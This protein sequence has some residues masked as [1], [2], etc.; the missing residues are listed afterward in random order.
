MGKGFVTLK[1]L[2]L[3]LVLSFKYSLGLKL[4]A[5]RISRLIKN[6]YQSLGGI[7]KLFKR[8]KNT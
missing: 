6:I 7:K 4:G 3:F 2:S 8:R 5:N 1:V